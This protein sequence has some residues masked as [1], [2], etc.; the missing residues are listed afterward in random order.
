M[1]N[2]R[3]FTSMRFLLIVSFLFAWGPLSSQPKADL[4]LLDW[5]PVSQMV[6]KETKVMKPKFPVIDM[7]NHLRRLENTEHYLEEMDK[8]GVEICIGLDG[9]SKDDFYKKH[10]EV[11]QSVSKERF[12]IYFS[13]DFSKI[14]EP[15]FGEKE[16]QKLEDAVKN[17]GIKG[18]KIF[19]SLGLGFKDKSGEFIKVDD[20]RIDPI[21]A[22]CGELG[23]P[24]M[25]HVSD[26]KAFHAGPID[27]YNER[28]DE[29]AGNPSWS[30]YPAEY[31]RK[32]EILEARNRMI[33]KHPNTIFIGAH[34]GNL[35]EELGV[36]SMWLDQYPN[37]YVG[38]S[39]RISELGRQP[40]TARKFFIKYQDR[41]LF[42]TD[43]P[44]DA[45]A[46]SV[47]YRFLET[48]DEYIDPTPAH[49]QQGRWMIYGLYLPDEV[50]EKVYYKNAL[51]IMDMIKVN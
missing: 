21:W 48:D 33:A 14:D 45:E 3:L 2:Y 16:A 10:L 30:F 35:P 37:F 47:Y 7:H 6:V 43:T 12:Q 32:E 22:K 34:V 25:I 26:P 4:K 40:Y 46:Y 36:V 15:G 51:K 42:G 17:M 29:L 28:Y 1:N 49:K 50:L 31:P 8:A 20:P 18:L 11:S 38:I 41:I 13:P 19:K 44:P 23:I 5:K 24:V 27:E 39:A 9:H